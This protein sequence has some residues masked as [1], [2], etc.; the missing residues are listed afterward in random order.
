MPAM[1][2]QKSVSDR[3]TLIPYLRLWIGKK[4]SD[5]I[6]HEHSWVFQFGDAGAV[7]VECPWRIIADNRIALT[8]SD[9]RQKF[10]LPAPVDALAMSRTLLSNRLVSEVTIAEVSG[11]L[12]VL[13]EDQT[14]LELINNSSGYEAW[15]AAMHDSIQNIL[16]I[17]QGGGQISIFQQSTKSDPGP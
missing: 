11:D 16:I 10:G 6:R 9:D 3:Q 17:A 4:C 13:F 15:Q 12:R 5:I 8:D 2:S 14:L 7:T 1:M